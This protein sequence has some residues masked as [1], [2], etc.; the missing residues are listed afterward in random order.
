MKTLPL[1]C[2]SALLPVLAWSGQF[3]LPSRSARPV[4]YGRGRLVGFCDLNRSYLLRNT[5]AHHC[6]T[7]L[8]EVIERRV[9][10]RRQKYAYALI[11]CFV[12]LQR[13]PA[14]PVDLLLGLVRCKHSNASSNP[15]VRLTLQLFTCTYHHCIPCS[16]LQSVRLATRLLLLDLRSNNKFLALEF[17]RVVKLFPQVYFTIFDLYNWLSMK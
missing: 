4:A 6:P 17:Q 15:H 3:F 5:S 10:L 7:D 1:I 2:S 11:C 8:R 12:R 14:P 13:P 16:G 9:M